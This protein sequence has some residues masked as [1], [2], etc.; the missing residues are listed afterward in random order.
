M[1]PFFMRKEGS[2]NSQPGLTYSHIGATALEGMQRLCSRAH[3]VGIPLCF[4]WAYDTQ[5]SQRAT[6]RHELEESDL[7]EDSSPTGKNSGSSDLGATCGSAMAS[8]LEI[9]C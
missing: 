6:C 8:H 5:S 4:L 9:G 2:L 3:I 7:G 1:S